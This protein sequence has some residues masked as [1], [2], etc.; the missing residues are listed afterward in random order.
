MAYL[1]LIGAVAA[2]VFQ[3]LFATLYNRKN[4]AYRE[5]TP[6]YNVIN[7]GALVV[8]WGVLFFTDATFL[9]AP[10][11]DLGTVFYSV[12]FSI[13]FAMACI[14]LINALNTGPITLTSLILQFSCIGSAIWG[15]FFWDAEPTPLVIVGILLV[16]VSLVLCLYKGKEEKGGAKINTKWIIYVSICFVGNLICMIVQREQQ[17]RY[18]GAY[19]NQLMLV[20]MIFALIL[21]IVL[22][23][24]SNRVDSAVLVKRAWFWP[25]LAGAS[26][27]LLNFFMM[28]LAVATKAKEI[29]TSLIDPTIA[30]V[31]LA[32]TTVISYLAFKEKLRWWQ[33]IGIGVGIG[34]SL[35]LSL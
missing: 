20:A 10:S 24:R 23:L 31:P 34:A 26:N 14:G 3:T 33:W 32:I 29:S 12:G 2:S 18:D 5:I 11:F 28:K 16:C 15:F 4:A 9:A 19:G 1:F 17:R 27:L 6:L 21:S 7:F 22:Y 25:V 30:V 8:L 35:L 13:G